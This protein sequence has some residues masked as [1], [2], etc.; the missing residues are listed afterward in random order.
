MTVISKIT[1]FDTR[2]AKPL[3]RLGYMDY[4]VIN[5]G[6]IFSKRRPQLDPQGKI[7]SG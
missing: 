5:D 3:G 2:K 6:N 7:I 1:L 4:G